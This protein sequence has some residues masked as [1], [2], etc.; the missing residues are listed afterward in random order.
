MRHLRI[1]LS[2]GLATALIVICTSCSS[3][4]KV[5]DESISM[6]VISSIGDAIGCRCIDPDNHYYT[7]PIAECADK[8]YNA[9][10]PDDTTKLFGALFRLRDELER[11]RIEK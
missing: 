11:C 3:V 1:L 5:G 7:I 8:K 10:S 6:C 9:M 2:K 4:P